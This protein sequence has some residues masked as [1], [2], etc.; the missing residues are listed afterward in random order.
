MRTLL[1]IAIAAGLVLSG[2]AVETYAPVEFTCNA[3]SAWQ[4]T[5]IPLHAG[6][7]LSIDYETGLWTADIR[8]GLSS[9]AGNPHTP[10]RAGDVLPTAVRSALVGRIG[11]SVFL[12]GSKFDGTVPSDGRLYCVINTMITKSD[13]SALLPAD[14]SVTMRARVSPA[15]PT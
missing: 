4:N 3:Q 9:P 6:D 12:I 11:D 13:A 7:R 8:N 5:G 14:G 10:A 15:T 1:P 2:C